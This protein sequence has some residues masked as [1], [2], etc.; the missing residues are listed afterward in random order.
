MSDTPT[1]EVLEHHREEVEATG[2]DLSVVLSDAKF[3]S[4]NAALQQ[5]GEVRKLVEAL[6]ASGIAETDLGIASVRVNASKGMLVKSSSATYVLAVRCREPNKVASVIDALA[7]VKNCSLGHVTWRYDVPDSVRQGWLAT[8]VKRA[9]GAADAMA[10]AL[11]T[12]I[13]YVYRVADETYG[14][15][16]MRRHQH[17]GY[18]YDG[19]ELAAPGSAMKRMR[20]EDTL[21]GMELAP[22]EE[23]LVKVRVWFAIAA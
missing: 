1:I 2:A 23:R 5:A 22:K 10:A 18:G 21:E 15:S 13:T 9:R 3:F 7:T 8:C 4:G 14:A 19:I 11:G 20:V 17:D 16:A 6:V 12:R